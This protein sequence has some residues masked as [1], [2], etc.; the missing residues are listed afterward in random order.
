MSETQMNDSTFSRLFIIMILAMTILTITIMVLASL[1][2]S[3]V[4]AKLDERYEQESTQSIAQ[5]IAPVGTFS[6]ETVAAPVAV[7][8]VPLTGEEVYVSCGACHDSGTLGAPIVSAAGAADWNTRLAQ[9]L[10]T[11]YN[12]AINGINNMPAKGGNASLSDDEIKA[13]VDYMLERAK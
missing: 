6:A 12:H 10:D 8:A 1:A 7:A 11:L 4:N 9:G 5:R 2:S 13:A 3:G